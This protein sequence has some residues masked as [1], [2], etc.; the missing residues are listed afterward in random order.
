V[1]RNLTPAP[2]A[3]AADWVVAELTT[4]GESVLS[5]VPAGFETYLRIFHPAYRRR[6]EAGEVAAVSWAEIAK[7][8]GKVAHPGMQL[9]V[10]TGR[11]WSR[12]DQPPPDIDDWPEVGS[13]PS[14]LATPLVAALTPHT[15][16]PDHCWFAIWFGWG[17]LQDDNLICR[18]PRFDLPALTYHLLEG[19]IDNFVTG[20]APTRQFPYGYRSPSLC[21]P[22]DST[23]CLATEIDFNSTYVGCSEACSRDILAPPDVEALVVDQEGRG[24]EGW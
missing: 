14:E 6:G 16:T 19:P 22:D 8:H 1:Q 4:F 3:R 11:E 7:T 12:N 24:W 9:D 15:A 18:S 2:D 10:I 5:V 17:D 23:W 13:F 21:W 20:I